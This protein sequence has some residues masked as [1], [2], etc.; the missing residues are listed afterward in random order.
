M[1]SV[2]APSVVLLIDTD[3]GLRAQ[4]G[5][6]TEFAGLEVI[7][8][9]RATIPENPLVGVTTMAAVFPAGTPATTVNAGPPIVKLPAAPL[10]VTVKLMVLVSVTEPLVPVRV[11]A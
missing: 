10:G 5:G 3:V 1:A 2:D 8:H 9:A 6:L 11:T 7:A 4:A